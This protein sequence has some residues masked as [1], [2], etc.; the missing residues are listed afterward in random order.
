MSLSSHHVVQY[1]VALLVHRQHS[2]LVQPGPDIL[3]WTLMVAVLV[4]KASLN[5]FFMFKPFKLGSSV[6]AMALISCSF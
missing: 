2:V 4:Q 1:Y 5:K 3:V 6:N